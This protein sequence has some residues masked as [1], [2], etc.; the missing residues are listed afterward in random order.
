MQATND[1]P[2]RGL[3]G[4]LIL[5]VC[6]SAR[7]DVL[8]SAR[9]LPD[10][11]MLMVSVESV[12]ELR[13]AAQKTSLYALYKDPAMQEFVKESEKRITKAIETAL[14]DFWQEKEVEN[15]PEQLPWPEGRLVAGVSLFSPSVS[16]EINAQEAKRKIGLRMGFR[17]AVLADMS[18]RIEQTRQ[19]MQS[20]STGA[21]NAGATVKREEIGGVE[22][23]VLAPK[24]HPDDPVLH[25]GLKDNWLVVTGDTA[26][27][28]E[29]TESIV[30]RVGRTLP[31]SL[32]EKTGFNTAVR[33]LGDAQLFAFV[34]VDAIRSQIAGIGP[35]KVQVERMIKAVGFDNV[36]GITAAI[37]VAGQRNHEVVSRTLIGIDGPKTGIPG[38]LSE[39]SG[40]LKIPNRLLTREAVGF[41]C[42]N[43]APANIFDRIAKIVQDAKFL[44]LN[45]MVQAGMAATAGEAGQPPVQLRD[46]V[47]AQ[48]AA[49]LFATW[50][51]EKPYR[52]DGP[53]RF[54]IGVPVQDGARLDTAL[55]RIHRAFLGMR[56]ELRRELL[57]HAIYLLP[58][59]RSVTSNQAAD[60]KGMAFAVAGDSL[61]FGH[62][63]E[64]EQAI[65]T[66]GREPADTIA[67]DPM[68][69]YA[70]ESLPSQACLY[71]YR[72]DRLDTE[73][74][75][76]A[77]KQM[78]RDLA[79]RDHDESKEQDDSS[80][81][82]GAM[83]KKITGY[84]DLNR[85]PEF[86]A[87]EKYW[88]ASVGYM[89]SRPEGLYGESIMLKPPQQ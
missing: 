72:N 20:L 59:R 46:D 23:H 28:T 26:P 52:L 3:L 10:D 9:M 2:M 62:V 19:V 56:T 18:S 79:G 41:V 83:L 31:G 25:Y 38:L 76:T 6:A 13:A 58:T 36:T 40:P 22:L 84:V 7:A 42:A 16:D 29:F 82:I 61:V 33:T 70:R 35:N 88:G 4:F 69:R 66:I 43:Y 45:M 54:L 78:A 39:G 32:A 57:D 1:R 48:M 37:E 60:E 5:S 85:L 51:M 12:S 81:P 53:T 11:M 49:P 87:V 74:T 73:I 77:F 64:V 68:F 47:L 8:E 89:Q 71:A 65:R 24:D 30:R 80:D 50:K 44:D 55:G 17:F 21:A 14:K 27:G 15:P 34:N 63:E 86:K 75:W 67:S